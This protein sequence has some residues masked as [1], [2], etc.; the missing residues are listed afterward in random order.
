MRDLA[1]FRPDDHGAAGPDLERLRVAVVNQ[2]RPVDV[3][4]SRKGSGQITLRSAGRTTA[5]VDAPV[6]KTGRD[7]RIGRLWRIQWGDD[8]E[9]ECFDTMY[10]TLNAIR[11]RWGRCHRGNGHSAETAPD[12]GT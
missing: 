8:S 6:T 3:G 11:R 5:Y 7:R 9:D 2:C 10:E 4:C 12:Y 1:E